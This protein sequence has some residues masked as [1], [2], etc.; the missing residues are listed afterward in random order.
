MQIVTFLKDELKRLFTEKDQYRFERNYPNPE[1]KRF[2]EW[3]DEFKLWAS[4][5][6]EGL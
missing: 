1:Q 4:K 6:F 2:V 3:P 5:F